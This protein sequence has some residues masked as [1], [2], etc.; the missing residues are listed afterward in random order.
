MLIWWSRRYVYE[1]AYLVEKE[2]QK[3]NSEMT[4]FG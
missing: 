1:S 2:E 3:V 4:A